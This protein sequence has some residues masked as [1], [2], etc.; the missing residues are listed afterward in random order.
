MAV[1][2]LG[3]QPYLQQQAAGKGWCDVDTSACIC[4]AG[5]AASDVASMHDVF[6][7]HGFASSELHAVVATAQLSSPAA[8]KDQGNMGTGHMGTGPRQHGHLG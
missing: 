6:A 2:L 5:Q 8:Q 7:A 4:K 1:Q 3:S